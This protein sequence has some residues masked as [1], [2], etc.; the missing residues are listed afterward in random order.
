MLLSDPIAVPPCWYFRLSFPL[1]DDAAISIGRLLGAEHMI[2]M[3]ARARRRAV[4]SMF[5]SV[6]SSGGSSMGTRTP[7]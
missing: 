2:E 5:P 7:G 4:G 6:S 1:G 3:V